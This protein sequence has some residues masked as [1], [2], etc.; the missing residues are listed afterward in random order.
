MISRLKFIFF[1]L[2]GLIIGHGS[3]YYIPTDSRL[4]EDVDLLKTAG[5]IRSLPS[6]SKPW[7]KDEFLRF[8]REAESAAQGRYL[9]PAQRSAL[10][11]L[12]RELTEK[13]M[14]LEFDL[15]ESRIWF[16]PFS[17]G[18]V[19]NGAQR[20]SLGMKVLNTPADRFFC[21]ERI[22]MILLNP[23][24][25]RVLDSSGWHNPKTRVVSWQDRI[26]WEM[27]RAYFGFKLPWLRLELGRDEWYWG[28][29]Y[30]SSVMLSDQAPALDQIQFTVTGRN[31]KFVSFT[32][33]LS[34]WNERHRFLSAQ[35][36]EVLLV[37]RLVLGAAMFNVY[38]WESA[39]DFGGFIN[40]LLP[41]Y[42]SE[43]NSGHDDNL[44]VGGDAVV[45]L[46]RSK[47]YAQL[48]LDNYEFNTRKQSPN[49]VGWQFGFLF[50]PPRPLDLRIEY[51]GIT[52]FTYYHRLRDIM[53]ENFSVPLGHQIGPDADQ[54]WARLRFSPVSWL[55]LSVWGDYTRRG[56]YNRGDYE[57]LSYDVADSIFIKKYYSFPARGYDYET[58]ELLEEVERC[59]RFGPELEITPLPDLY[60]NAWFALAFCQNKDG[61][62][63]EKRTTPEFLIKLEYRY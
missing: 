10:N 16:E 21:Y 18:W 27:E 19:E 56:Y 30:L 32:A 38:T 12:H 20:V 25:G 57:R 49:C 6:T 40:P 61:K 31:V 8:L 11:R 23:K 51:T 43:A 9:N 35:R 62:I 42:F 17:R 58:G 52:P 63:G 24:Q 41:L 60:I 46:P 59:S 44:L 13:K 14:A 48:L 33:L 55:G 47:L 22:E 54:L 37:K 26:L 36:L 2:S 29:G 1:I 5:L 28:P 3:Q 34:R 39:R 50:L 7:T 15:P 4:Y 45:Y 53:F